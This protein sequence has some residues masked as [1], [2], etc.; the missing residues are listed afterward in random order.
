M[1]SIGEENAS[2]FVSPFFENHL[3]RA[4][5][6]SDKECTDSNYHLNRSLANEEPTKE[7][8]R[9]WKSTNCKID[10]INNPLNFHPLFS[11]KYLKSG[12]VRNPIVGHLDCTDAVNYPFIE[13][14]LPELLEKKCPLCKKQISWWKSAETTQDN[15]KG[16]EPIQQLEKKQLHHPKNTTKKKMRPFSISEKDVEKSL[17]KE[18]FNQHYV[19]MYNTEKRIYAFKKIH[20]TESG[21]TGYESRKK[22]QK[23]LEK[24]YKNCLTLTANDCAELP[25]EK[26]QIPGWK[27]VFFQS[28]KDESCFLFD[29][30]KTYASSKDTLDSLWE[31]FFKDLSASQIARC[32]KAA[33]RNYLNN[34][35]TKSAY[36]LLWLLKKSSDWSFPLPSLNEL[37]TLEPKTFRNKKL[38]IRKIKRPIP[39]IKLIFTEITL[40]EYACRILFNGDDLKTVISMTIHQLPNLP[41]EFIGKLFILCKNKS[42]LLKSIHQHKAIQKTSHVQKAI[43]YLESL[44]KE[45]PISVKKIA[46]KELEKMNVFTEQELSKHFV[47]LY[48]EIHTEDFRHPPKDPY[49]WTQDLIQTDSDI[50][51]KSI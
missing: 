47:D 24:I 39:F 13:K 14:D 48:N 2:K 16:L 22:A 21:F 41:I 38:E 3:E 23:L 20:F 34:H 11:K 18:L 49:A 40:F 26:I 19:E 17:F 4:Y 7:T 30:L 33:F 46:L 43:Q 5:K 45:N 12:T 6:K 51:E 8:M 32:F 31:D 10:L 50:D 25:L 42:T 28:L 37:R 36:I 29:L 15:L 9:S 27:A 44:L 35:D 1:N